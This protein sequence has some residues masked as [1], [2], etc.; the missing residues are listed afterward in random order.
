[1]AQKFMEEGNTAVNGFANAQYNHTTGLV[2]NAQ[3]AAITRLQAAA[4]KRSF[5]NTVA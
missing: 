2:A 3:Q 4:K 1:M 5:V